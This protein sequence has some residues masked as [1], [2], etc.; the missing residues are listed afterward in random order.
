MLYGTMEHLSMRA[1][2]PSGLAAQSDEELLLAYRR[3]GNPQSFEELVRRFEKEMYGYL[4]HYLGDAEMAEDVFQQTFLQV[5]LKCDQFEEG[6]KVRPWLYT[7]ATNQAIDYQR[8][9]RRHRAASLDRRGMRDF[10][11]EPGA[12]IETLN[13]TESGPG[14]EAETAEQV[15]QLRRAVD[16]LPE[17]TRQVIILVYFQGLKYREAADI[18]G[19][20]VGT[21]K[22]RLH[23]AIE[24]LSELMAHLQL[25]R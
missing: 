9:N 14:E 23:T 10:E 25:P 4:R 18:L 21:I 16:E 13:S 17:G 15:E 22:S 19:I 7:V 8:R 3:G 11:G 6:R 5:H 20:P 24:K 12:L 1:S 2:D